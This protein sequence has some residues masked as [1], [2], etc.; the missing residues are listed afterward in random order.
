MKILDIED[1]CGTYGEEMTLGGLL[2]E[3]QGRRVHK[4]PRCGGEGEILA[5]D[6]FFRDPKLYSNWRLGYS[7]KNGAVYDNCPLCGG[8]GDTEKEYRP[9]MKAVYVQDGYECD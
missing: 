7:Y 6:D 4:C 8:G 1:L 2:R 5:D 3:L 9:R